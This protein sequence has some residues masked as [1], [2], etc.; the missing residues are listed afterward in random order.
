MVAREAGTHEG[1]EAAC[2]SGVVFPS[3]L[4]TSTALGSF[5]YPQPGQR[6]HPYPPP[7]PDP[8][9][10]Q[11]DGQRYRGKFQASNHGLIFLVT[12]LHLGTHQELPH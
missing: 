1:R 2:T 3:I 10:F 8:L 9:P 12:S 7:F 4:T 5:R 11:E 6:P